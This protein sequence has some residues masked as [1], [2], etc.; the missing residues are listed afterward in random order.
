V[1]V[2]NFSAEFGRAAGGTVNAV[3]KSGTNALRGELLPLR[4]DKFTAKDPFFP[5]GVDRPNSG[6]TFGQ[7]RRTIGPTRRSS[8]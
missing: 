8:S 6:G 2:S 3:T 4:D 5:A 7:R 1:G